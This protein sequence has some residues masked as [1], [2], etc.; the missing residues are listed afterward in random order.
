MEEFCPAEKITP[1]IAAA[2]GLGDPPYVDCASPPRHSAFSSPEGLALFLGKLRE[3]SGG[4]PVGIKLCVGQP[5]EF[6]ALLHAFLDTGI[7]PDFI[8]VR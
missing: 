3:L 7:V 4:K 2:R 1:E 6:A 5:P 8:T